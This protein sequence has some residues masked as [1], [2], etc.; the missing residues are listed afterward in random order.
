[1]HAY[2][3]PIFT[4][5]QPLRLPED[6]ISSEG[7]L[8][9]TAR[10]ARTG[11]Q[12]YYG[13]ELAGVDEAVELDRQYRVYRPEQAVFADAALASFRDLPVTLGHPN[14]EMST[15]NYRDHVIGHVIGDVQRDGDFIRAELS[16]RDA[17]AIAKIRSGEATQ[18]SVGYHANVTLKTGVTPSGEKYDAIQSHIRGNHIALVDAA[19]CGPECRIGDRRVSG[20]D[21]ASCQ[22]RKEK[23]MTELITLDGEAITLAE[24]VEK[25][26]GSNARIAEALKEAE[27]TIARLHSELETKSGEVEALQQSPT[28]ETVMDAKVRAR[29]HILMEASEILGDNTALSDRSDSDIRRRVIDHVYGDGFARGASDHAVLGMYKVAVRD[30]GRA[31]DTVNGA[32]QPGSIRQSSLVNAF[33]RRNERLQNAWRGHRGQGGMSS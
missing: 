10:I 24:A 5:R 22:T 23:P 25:L 8:T 27:A 9:L 20:C 16:I 17:T 6:R 13:H 11:I 1:M 31:L 3:N 21:C 2:E 19:R 15:N 12:T 14:A 18:L 32:V 28:T 7:Y 33:T 26:R 29:A 30:A 4:D